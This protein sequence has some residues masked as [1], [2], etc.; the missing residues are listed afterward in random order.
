MVYLNKFG[1]QKMRSLFFIFSVLLF[2]YCA[3]AQVINIE[4][5]RFLKD[6]NGFIGRADLNFNV[7]QTTSQV[8]SLGMNVHSQYVHDNHRIL[9]IGDLA[10]IKAGKQDLSLIHI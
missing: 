4:S 2:Q 5:K 3:T 1:L 8:I 10:F 9:A 6:T 7:T